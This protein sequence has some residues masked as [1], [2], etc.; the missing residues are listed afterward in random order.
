MKV[1]TNGLQFSKNA[2]NVS[3]RFKQRGAKT[4]SIRSSS[5]KSKMNMLCKR[6]GSWPR[7]ECSRGSESWPGRRTWRSS[8]RPR[9][10]RI[11]KG[12]ARSVRS[13]RWRSR[14]RSKNLDAKLR[15]AS[16]RRNNR[17][18]RRSKS[19]CRETGCNEWSK[20]KWRW[21]NGIAEKGQRRRGRQ[22]SL[23]QRS[24]TANALHSA[25]SM[26]K[27]LMRSRLHR[28]LQLQCETSNKRRDQ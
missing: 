24:W 16:W 8:S 19:S 12:K 21:K 26:Q 10:K 27:I 17:K 15:Q 23:Y 3:K 13:R 6:R 18:S 20:G 11:W 28:W 22:T 7:N 1:L 5:S 4:R 14:E 2:E 9:W 25:T